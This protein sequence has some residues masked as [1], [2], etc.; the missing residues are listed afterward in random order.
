MIDKP[1]LNFIID[2]V[3][4]LCMMAIAG[5]AFLMKFILIPGK[6]RA[7]KYGRSVELLL[8]GMDRHSWGT[9]HLAIGLV[10]LGLL[11]L[12][13]ILHWSAI[14]GLFR[15]LVDSQKARQAIAPAFVLVSLFLLVSP[16]A[17]R[18]EVREGGSN[19]SEA[20]IGSCEGCPENVPHELG[21]R[22][23]DTM[24]IKGFMTLAEVSTRYDVPIHCLKTHLG[25]PAAASD[26]ERLGTLKQTCGFTMSDVERVIARYRSEQ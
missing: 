21:R 17:V 11:A 2:A 7:V 15:R 8:F 20:I 12:H 5:L 3:M 23:D 13:I 22:A 9:V 10:L 1:Q 19:H 18:P 25:I 16:L 26:N 6:E 24:T 14:V 4:F